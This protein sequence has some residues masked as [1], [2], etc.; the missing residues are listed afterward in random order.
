MV[1]ELEDQAKKDEAAEK[2][3]EKTS[4]KKYN[5]KKGDD[6][7]GGVKAGSYRKSSV[8]E[9]LPKILQDLIT[10]Q[11]EARE[12]IRSGDASRYGELPQLYSDIRSLE[13]KRDK[14]IK[15]VSNPVDDNKDTE[16]VEKQYKEFLA[17]KAA[18]HSVKDKKTKY[19]FSSDGKEFTENEIKFAMTGKSAVPN[20]NKAG[21]ASKQQTRD[22][23]GNALT[24]PED[25]S[26]GEE[27]AAPKT[28]EE[29]EKAKKEQPADRSKREEAERAQMDADGYD[30]YKKSTFDDKG[31]LTNFSRE[32]V[33][34]ATKNKVS[35]ADRKAF[36]AKYQKRYKEKDFV[37]ENKP[38]K[39]SSSGSS[40]RGGGRRS[41]TAGR[42]SDTEGIEGDNP[43]EKTPSTQSAEVGADGSTKTTDKDDDPKLRG[44]TADAD[45]EVG[46]TETAEPYQTEE[47]KQE[48]ADTLFDKTEVKEGKRPG[49]LE[50]FEVLGASRSAPPIETPMPTEPL[51]PSDIAKK[52]SDDV[53]KE[54]KQ[55]GKASIERLKEEIRAYH[56]VYDNNIKEFR[57][58][59]HKKQK[60]DAL[61]SDNIEVVRAHHKKMEER[62]REYYRG[63][64]ADSLNVGVI[65]PIDTYLQQ[66]LSRST[67]QFSNYQPPASAQSTS[68]AGATHRHQHLTKKGHDPYGHAIA[69]STYYQRG[70]IGSYKQQ[71]VANH[72][73]RIKSATTSSAVPDPKVYVDAPLNNYLQRPLKLSSSLKIKS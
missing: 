62:I 16:Y 63:G 11:R 29:A 47:E 71:P 22:R 37:P 68:S 53:A 38:P 30:A 72:T 43:Q 8:D 49:T 39:S 13:Q 25:Q 66:Y 42:S 23:F 21:L 45:G 57:E 9:T 54:N 10:K 17:G 41:G 5:R 51:K 65:V 3:A 59:P 26:Q 58:N 20:L 28:K 73:I 35:L 48:E 40:L 64:D 61:K 67:P 7:G 32:Y 12:I 56:L 15:Q 24:I 27:T 50:E 70:G 33:E 60:D 18:H 14:V 4:T 19:P 52:R 2:A 55:R 6:L 44:A 36:D 31:N 69:S 46:G 1:K 34:W